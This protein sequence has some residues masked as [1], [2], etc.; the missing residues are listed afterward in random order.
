MF[1][2]SHI[3]LCFPLLAFALCSCSSS[4]P[5]EEE[6]QY[7]GKFMANDASRTAAGDKSAET[8]TGVLQDAREKREEKRLKFQDVS[9]PMNQ[10][11]Y[12]VFP[13]KSSSPRSEQ[14]HDASREGSN[15]IF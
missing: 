6:N 15:S 2:I 9:R 7:T 12:K 8:L 13:W 3:A 5:K 1:K 10:D 14:L 4:A 11:S